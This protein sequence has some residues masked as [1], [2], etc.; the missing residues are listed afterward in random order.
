LFVGSLRVGKFQRSLPLYGSVRRLLIVGGVSTG[1]IG[2]R[3]YASNLKPLTLTG[4]LLKR[5]LS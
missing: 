2:R 4:R 5:L 3:V 1:N